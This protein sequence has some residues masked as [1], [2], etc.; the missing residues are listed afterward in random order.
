MNIGAVTKQNIHSKTNLGM[1]ETCLEA[2]R[3]VQKQ[4]QI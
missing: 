4:K 3:Y 1:I 2:V